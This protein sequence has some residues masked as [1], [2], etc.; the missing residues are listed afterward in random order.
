VG[1]GAIIMKGIR[2][3][4]CQAELHPQA[5]VC[6]MCGAEVD[7]AAFRAGAPASRWDEHRD[8]LPEGLPKETTVGLEDQ[9]HDSLTRQRKAPAW[10]MGGWMIAPVAALRMNALWLVLLFVAVSGA[11]IVEFVTLVAGLASIPPLVPVGIGLLLWVGYLYV[12]VRAVRNGRL[13]AV[14]AVSAIALVLMA[15]IEVGVLMVSGSSFAD[16]WHDVWRLNAGQ[17]GALAA[18]F[19]GGWVFVNGWLVIPVFGLSGLLWTWVAVR[20]GGTWAETRVWRSGVPAEGRRGFVLGSALAGAGTYFAAVLLTGLVVASVVDTDSALRPLRGGMGALGVVDALTQS[21]PTSLRELALTAAL[22][23]ALVAFVGFVVIYVRAL[24]TTVPRLLGWAPSAWS[25]PLAASFAGGKMTMTVAGVLGWVY[26]L[27]RTWM[28]IA[29]T[30]S[31]GYFDASRMG[32]LALLSVPLLLWL[33]WDQVALMLFAA[34]R[35]FLGTVG[36]TAIAP[37]WFDAILWVVLAV[38]FLVGGAHAARRLDKPSGGSGW[39]TGAMVGLIPA[40]VGL[41]FGILNWDRFGA[42]FAIGCFVTSILWGVVFGG[43]GGFVTA[44]NVGGILEASERLR[45]DGG[46]GGRVRPTPVPFTESVGSVALASQPVGEPRV[47]PVSSAGPPA[48]PQPGPA[49]PVG[50]PSAAV[51]VRVETAEPEDGTLPPAEAG[52]APEEPPVPPLR[53]RQ[54]GAGAAERQASPQEPGQQAEAAEGAADLS[55][56]AEPALPA[57]SLRVRPAVPKPERVEAPPAR[58]ET[59]PVHAAAQIPVAEPTPAP[60]VPPVAPA[61]PVV[62][63]PVVAAVPAVVPEPPVVPEPVV[64]PAPPVAP[65]PAAEPVSVPPAPAPVPPLSAA[66]YDWPQPTV[67]AGVPPAPSEFV[68]APAPVPPP[69]QRGLAP[70]PARRRRSAPGEDPWQALH[71]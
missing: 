28:D 6:A 3:P 18:L 52:H 16:A 24:R 5:V 66:T 61:P 29:R 17:T 53:V 15:T 39:L 7:A 56:S 40:M 68:P 37:E 44:K 71:E 64:V 51:P 41:L 34:Q 46:L 69:S 12:F 47:E 10:E 9:L 54:A 42:L 55:E 21:A 63:E 48:H 11:V 2:C 49:E 32:A 59:A 13:G 70:P 65:A 23:G 22:S 26:L 4:N 35:L 58:A 38:A 27:L 62:P 33:G 36:G 45:S 50:L 30:G 60:P 1:W 25:G 19:A 20:V 43:L 31:E 57:S 8:L 14:M 67:P